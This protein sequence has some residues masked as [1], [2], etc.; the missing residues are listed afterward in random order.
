[1]RPPNLNK[2]ENAAWEWLVNE[3]GYCPDEIQRDGPNQSP[4]FICPDEKYEAKRPSTKGKYLVTERQKEAFD[5]LDPTILI[6]HEDDDEPRATFRWSDR[7]DTYWTCHT[8]QQRQIRIHV[9]D[10]T[11]RRWEALLARIGTEGGEEAALEQLL[12]YF[13]EDASRIDAVRGAGL[14]Q[15]PEFRSP[16]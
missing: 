9:N 8:Y 13:E 1:M 14:V 5:T 10:E 4:D 15:N 12:A 6:F 2:T 16:E 3:K 11:K 7:G